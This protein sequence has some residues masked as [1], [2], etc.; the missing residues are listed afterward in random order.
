MTNTERLKA[1]A[2]LYQAIGQDDDANAILEI[3][4]SHSLLLTAAQ[5][6]VSV[7]CS[8]TSTVQDV[9]DSDTALRQAI[10]VSEAI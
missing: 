5:N 2:S 1:I 8:R 7:Y 10:L 3:M 6:H 4:Y 9:S